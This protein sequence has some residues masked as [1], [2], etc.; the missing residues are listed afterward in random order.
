MF[1]MPIHMPIEKFH[2]WIDCDGSSAFAKIRYLVAKA[3]ML[4][5]YGEVTEPIS[6]ESKTRNK[7]RQNPKTVDDRNNQ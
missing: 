6:G 1:G 4:G 7:K 3:A 2:Q 5:H